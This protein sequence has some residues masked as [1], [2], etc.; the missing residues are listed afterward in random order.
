L[1]ADKEIME[2][3][4]SKE[5]NEDELLRAVQK[6]VTLKNFDAVYLCSALIKP[7]FRGKGYAKNSMKTSIKK[8]AGNKKPILFYW[9]FSEEGAGLAKKIAEELNLEI[10]KRE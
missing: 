1:P 3:F 7:E 10:R 2:K 9:K 4:I 5:M 6:K 8:I